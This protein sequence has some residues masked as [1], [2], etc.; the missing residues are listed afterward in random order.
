VYQALLTRRYL[1]SK[2]MPLLAAAAVMLCVA[3]E[4]IVWSVMGGFLHMLQNS[5]RVLIGDVAISWPN[6]GFAH[7]DDLIRRLEADPLVEAA[8]PTI[9]TAGF[10]SLPLGG[11]VQ[12]VLVKGVDGPSYARVAQYADSL[13]WRPLDRALPKDSRRQDPRVN[14]EYREAMGIL[15]RSGLS[16]TYQ[17][18]DD[19]EP[20]PAVVPGV[21]VSG[22]NNRNPGGWI[23]IGYF[24]P[25]NNVIL[26][27]FPVDSRGRP[28]EAVARAFP[29]ANEYRSGLYE[30]D[31]NT[32]LVRF[33]ALQSM[34]KMNEA[35]RVKVSPGS[36]GVTT[37]PATGRQTFSRPEV[38]DVDPARTTQVLV[39]GR[40][41]GTSAGL[42]SLKT[43]CEEVYA[44]FA[45]AHPDVPAPGLI[46]IGTWEDRNA[47]LIGAVKKETALVMFIFGVISLTSVFL[48]LA[49][50]WS[51]VSEKTKDIG[52]LRAM[53]AGRGGVAWLWLRYGLVIGTAGAVLGGA[54]AYLVVLNINPI[55]DWM[56][57]VLG[58]T[59]WDPKVYYF[60]EIPSRIEPWKAAAVLL[61][62]VTASVVGA[63]VPAI[64]AAYMDPVRSLR[65]E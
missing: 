51:M 3:T 58:L 13:W 50:F 41:A 22:Y 38:F 36:F 60:T 31:A 33:D 32:V 20:R 26:Y 65:F 52:I 40:Q 35:K 14:P 25:G 19:P 44:D 37:D 21:E 48:I 61:V 64:K 6:A 17:G 57:R 1:T 42:E 28:V 29:V 7:Y 16:L 62:G 45:R 12:T 34:L 4:L 49:I 46:R 63:L 54:A 11:Q 47:T 18:R 30:V 56:G 24:L 23:D 53:G 39:R 15:E 2:V 55:H 8:T 27:V 43:R 10:L 9:E 5:G 59:V